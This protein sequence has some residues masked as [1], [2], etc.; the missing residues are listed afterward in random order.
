ML[1][2][3]KVVVATVPE[4]HNRACGGW[5]RG[6]LGHISFRREIAICLV[7]ITVTRP[8]IMLR[9]PPM[10]VTTASIIR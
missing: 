9:F 3:K 2:G 4:R 7:K 5:L 6:E 8:M 1:R 10:Y